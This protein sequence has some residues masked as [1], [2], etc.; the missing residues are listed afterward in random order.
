MEQA[1]VA[2]SAFLDAL[3]LNL[4]FVPFQLETTTL[5]KNLKHLIAK[6]EADFKQISKVNSRFFSI[7]TKIR[8]SKNST[9]RILNS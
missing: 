4:L 8:R 3:E 6:E 2:L 9:L 7:A 5:R 1:R